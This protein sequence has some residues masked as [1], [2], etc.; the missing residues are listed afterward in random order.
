MKSISNDNDIE[1][2]IMWDIK[3]I[4]HYI[5]TNYEKFL[6]F[7]FAFLIIIL[8]DYISN[9]NAVIFAYPQKIP[10]L[11][12]DSKIKKNKKKVL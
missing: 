12:F 3:T 7:V 6:L 11:N 1:R 10:G 8:V 4:T 5:I 2:I 9:I